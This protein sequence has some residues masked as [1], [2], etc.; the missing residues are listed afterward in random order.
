MTLWS[1]FRELYCRAWHQSAPLLCHRIDWEFPLD[2]LLVAIVALIAYAIVHFWR[3]RRLSLR[4]HITVLGGLW[5]ACLV[6]MVLSRLVPG[7]W[8]AWY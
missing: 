7:E 5:L 2:L 8:E 3:L 6:A 1:L 4:T